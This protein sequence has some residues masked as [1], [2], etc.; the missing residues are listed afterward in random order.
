MRPRPS[1]LRLPLLAACLLL[2]RMCLAGSPP[3]I[4]KFENGSTVFVWDDGRRLENA[5]NGDQIF[6]NLDGRTVVTKAKSPPAVA[7]AV[8]V[9]APC[10]DEAGIVATN[11]AGKQLTCAEAKVHCSNVQLAEKCKRL[12]VSSKATPL[13]QQL[14]LRTA[15]A[16]LRTERGRLQM[17]NLSRTPPNDSS[18]KL[19]PKLQKRI[20]RTLRRDKGWLAEMPPVLKLMPRNRIKKSMMGVLPKPHLVANTAKRLVAEAVANAAKEEGKD[21]KMKE[22]REKKLAADNAKEEGE[23]W[24]AAEAAAANAAKAKEEN[25]ELA[26]KLPRQGCQGEGGRREKAGVGCRPRLP[27]RRRKTRK[28]WRRK[29]PRPRLP[30][31]RR[32]REKAGGGSCRGQGCQGEGGK[33]E[34]LA[35]EAAAAKAAKAKEERR[36]KAGGAAG[37]CCQGEGGRRE[38]AGGGSCRSRT[39]AKEEDEKRLA[40]EA[41]AANAAAITDASSAASD[42]ATDGTALAA[43]AVEIEELKIAWMRP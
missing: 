32:K 4:T 43:A 18:R 31:R 17:L 14:V 24:L 25:E 29:L 35:A 10:E 22:D 38:K 26:A 20:G 28:G 15:P 37:Q 6:T 21:G 13:L 16:K 41:A 36:E 23:K 12:L 2:P 34:R 42:R 1:A 33:R 3:T 11:E 27:R 30:R 9:R 19:P 5:A 39:K 40:A 7:A 8:P